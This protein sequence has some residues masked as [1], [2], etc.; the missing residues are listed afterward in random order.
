MAKA[1]EQA[2]TRIITQD[3]IVTATVYDKVSI[4]HLAYMLFKGSAS[5]VFGGVDDD[6][7]LVGR[8]VKDLLVFPYSEL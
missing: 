7:E 1:T 4:D 8:E 2:Q 6:T 5:A 3:G